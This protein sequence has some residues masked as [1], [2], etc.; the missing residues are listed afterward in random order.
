M[1]FFG[2]QE[3]ARRATRWLVA[4]FGLAVAGIIATVY[5][6]AV[7]LLSATDVQRGNWQPEVLLGIAA[8]TIGIVTIAALFKTSQLRAGGPAVATMLGGLPVDPATSDPHERRL[9]NIV[10]EM[11]IASG[12]PVPQVFV[13]QQEQGINAFAAGWGT[14]D[15]AVAVTRGCLEQLDR[16]ELQGVIAHEFSH[17]FHGDMRLN[18]RLMGVLF[19]I[20]CIATIGEIIVRTVGRS[21]MRSGNSKNKGGAAGIVL[22]G[23]VLWIIGYLGVFFAGLIKAAVSRQREYLADAAAVQY[24]RNPRGIG[25][26]LAKI[27]GIGGRLESAHAEEASHM[28]FA[29]GVKRLFGGL[30]ATHPPI[31]QRVERILPGFLKHLQSTGDAVAAV[32]ATPLPAGMAGLAGAAPAPRPATNPDA[33]FADL[34]NP[35]QE[36]VAQARQFLGNLPLELATAARDPHQARALVL[37]LLLDDQVAGRDAQLRLLQ[38]RDQALAYDVR[39]LAT[40][41]LKDHRGDR[42]PLL[43]LA[44]PAL[45]R[46]DETA[47]TTLRADARRIAMA[48]GRLSPF[49]LALLKTLERHVRLAG[50]LPRRPGRPAALIARPAE[51]SVVLSVLARAGATDEVAAARA[52][53][54]GLAQLQGVPTLQ[55]LPAPACTIEALEQGIDRLAELSP[56]GKRLLLQACGAAAANDGHIAPHEAELLRALAETWDCPVP[57]PL[58]AS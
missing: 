26:A 42:L 39:T 16:D 22:F 21:G 34:G 53:A 8:G 55:L 41:A 28:L 10:E 12:V 27:G 50:E 2:H 37:A 32:A 17:V 9:L 19:G 58:P 3:Q 40:S 20:L 14:A 30:H 5:I 45:R 25:L 13:L 11:S 23:I 7:V 56:F 51:A 35:R 1:D 38:E 48:D 36:H 15:A 47:K 57:P 49:E 18:I 54:A 33:M 4:W 6:A 46:L 24:T 44:V 31:E 52:F 43:E 29:D